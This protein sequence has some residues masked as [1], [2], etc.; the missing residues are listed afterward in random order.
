VTDE[1]GAAFVVATE[2]QT[3]SGT[4]VLVTQ[5]DIRQLQLATAAIRA[6]IA[7]LLRQTGLTAADLDQF[8][9]AGGFG[10][11]IRP[12]N[13]QRIGL[14]PPELDPERFAFAGNT[15]LAGARLTAVSLEARERAEA[16]AGRT[17]HVDL[18]LD[19]NFQ[20]EYVEA[21]FFPAE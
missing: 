9:V 17:R 20:M 15:S 16:L 13:A 3:A 18:S 14:L 8:V 11:Y 7:I 6:G 1:R 2:E 19:L 10:N 12:A 5:D 4:P 21:M